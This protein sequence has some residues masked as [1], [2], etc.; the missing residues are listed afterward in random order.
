[1]ETIEDSKN[2]S[3]DTVKLEGSFFESSRNNLQFRETKKMADTFEKYKV[4]GERD[5]S[6]V[7]KNFLHKVRPTL[8]LGTQRLI[9]DNQKIESI[10]RRFVEEKF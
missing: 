5:K 4:N 1:L 10:S 6:K 9:N 8:R 7:F 3:Q 2:H